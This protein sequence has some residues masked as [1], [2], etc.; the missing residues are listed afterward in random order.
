MSLLEIART[1]RT[2]ALK[3]IAQSPRTQRPVSNI[4]PI[5]FALARINADNRLSKVI[6]RRVTPQSV[7]SLAA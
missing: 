3:H 5:D 7:T 4:V 6:P 1:R 2:A